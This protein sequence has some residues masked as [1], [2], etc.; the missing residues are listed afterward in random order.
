MEHETV[1]LKSLSLDGMTGRLAR[2]IEDHWLIGL[3]ESNPAILGMFADRDRLPYRDLLPWSGEFAG[4]YITGALMICKLTRS[5]KLYDY[6]TAFIDELLTYQ[7]EDGYLGCYSKNCRLTGAF[8]Q[9]PEQTGATWD[10]WAHY[11]IMLGLTLWYE[12]TGNET[13]FDAVKKIAD[14]FMRTF[15]TGKRTV[16]QTGWAEMN[17]APYHIFALLFRMT[18]DRRYLDFALAI[19]GELSSP[20]AGDYIRHTLAGFEYWQCPKP[21]WESMH[22]IQGIAEMYRCTGDAKYLT[23]AGGI[24]RSILKTD[25]HNT[26]AFST[27]EAAIG[28]PFESGAIETCCVVAYNALAVDIFKLTGDPDIIDFLELSLYNAVTG[29]FSANGRWSTYDTPMEGARAASFHSI[30]FQCR[31]GSPELNCCSVNA[32][33][34]IGMLSDWMITRRD[35]VTFINFYE[36]LSCE[37]EDGLKITIAGAYPQPGKVTLDLASVKTERIALRIPS[38]SKQTILTV[39]KKPVKAP[40]GYCFLDVNGSARIELTLDFSPRLISGGG[41]FTGKSS[42]CYGPLLFGCD[43]TTCGCGFTALPAVSEKELNEARPCLHKDG[44]FRVVLPGITLCAFA[45]LGRNGSQY[46]TWLEVIKQ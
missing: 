15:Y 25:V 6:I 21:R 38:W 4:K 13:Y 3:R 19:E 16:L 28:S 45:D 20:G 44:S 22:I 23:A 36:E 37:T 12:Q 10:L 17:M 11:H 8:S 18:G 34:G 41:Q 7:D 35:D 42:V 14:L 1:K 24:F 30:N 9:N 43:V 32:P 26:G 29:S 33:R 46:K 31:P 2:G 5:Q 27:N 39:D 40:E